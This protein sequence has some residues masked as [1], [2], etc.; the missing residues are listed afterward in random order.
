MS[1]LKNTIDPYLF[2]EPAYGIKYCL[3][4]LKKMGRSYGTVRLSDSDLTDRIRQTKN[5]IYEEKVISNKREIE[6]L[7]TNLTDGDC[8]IN[9]KLRRKNQDGKAYKLKESNVNFKT[10]QILQRK[11]WFRLDIPQICDCCGNNTVLPYMTP[12]KEL[13]ELL[14]PQMGIHKVK[15]AIYANSNNWLKLCP[16]DYKM[17]IARNSKGYKNKTMHPIVRDRILYHRDTLNKIKPHTMRENTE[18]PPLNIKYKIP[19]TKKEYEKFR[20]NV[21]DYNYDKPANSDIDCKTSKEFLKD[22]DDILKKFTK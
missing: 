5:P 1:K 17:W 2:F 15:A 22:A 21:I 9:G 11:N 14:N 10:I 6:L 3:E 13:G 20:L 16:N 18:Q 12:Y 19:K 8:N 4:K 7:K